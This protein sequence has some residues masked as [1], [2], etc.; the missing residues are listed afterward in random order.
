MAKSEVK[1]RK[2]IRSYAG[3]ATGWAKYCIEPMTDKA[4]DYARDRVPVDTGSL[5]SSIT[6]DVW[7]LTGAIKAGGRGAR[8]AMLIEYGTVHMKARSFL[9]Y[10]IR[11]VKREFRAFAKGAWKEAFD[12]Q[13]TGA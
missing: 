4:A 5:K 6:Y 11:K 3:M 12:E 9:R 2:R 8:H 7:G 10:A 13:S 1:R